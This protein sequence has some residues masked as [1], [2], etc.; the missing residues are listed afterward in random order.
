MPDRGTINPDGFRTSEEVLELLKFK[1]PIADVVKR[2][3]EILS[4]MQH[5]LR[6]VT[7]VAMKK[8]DAVVYVVI[9]TEG[10]GDGYATKALFFDSDSALE[11]IKKY[12]EMGYSSMRMICH[13]KTEEP[14]PAK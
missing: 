13:A 5:V 4:Y 8:H 9:K 2:Q 7:E 14:E 3:Q 11:Y 1:G 10:T 12:P 6:Y